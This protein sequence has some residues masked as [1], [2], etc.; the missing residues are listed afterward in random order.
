MTK[1]SLYKFILSLL[2]VSIISPLL[3]LPLDV[4]AQ[5]STA[6]TTDPT[7]LLGDGVDI[8]SQPTV[9]YDQIP[10]KS[11]YGTYQRALVKNIITE[12]VNTTEGIKQQ[13]RYTIEILNGN[14]KNQT[15]NVTQNTEEVSVFN[16]SLGDKIIVFI[17]S[18]TDPSQPTIYL[19]TYDRTGLYIFGIILLLLLL[20]VLFGTS[21]YKLILALVLSLFALIQVALPLYL[22]GWPIALSCIIGFLPIG[23]ALIY[24][25]SGWKKQSHI[26]AISYSVSLIFNCIFIELITIWS[27]LGSTTDLQVATFFTDNPQLN[28]SYIILI[29]TLAGLFGLLQHISIVITS[30]IN[31][32][33]NENPNLALKKLFEHG[34]KI[35]QEL[36]QTNII[37]YPMVWIGALISILILRYQDQASWTFFINQNSI[38]QLLIP[39]LFASIG[40]IT[41]IPIIVYISSIAFAKKSRKTNTIHDLTSWQ[42]PTNQD[43]NHS[44]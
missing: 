27:K 16:P 19:Q 6:T 9:T 18:Q 4:K 39:P 44:A 43:N 35:S 2:I 38:A 15:F 13:T 20:F 32:Y 26:A 17:Q 23:I 36:L 8:Q 10:T 40:L 24:L 34:M 33:K 22:K 11:R 5:E 42:P 7:T 21:S 1:K 14:F 3:A 31:I 37:I 12:S 30:N 29:G 25:S 41:S 28:P